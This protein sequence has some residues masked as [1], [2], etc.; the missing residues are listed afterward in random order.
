MDE[1]TIKTKLDSLAEYESQRSL[2]DIQKSELLS[3]VQ[4][5]S[6]VQDIVADGNKRASALRVE[7]QQ[8]AIQIDEEYRA[9]LDAVVVPEEIRA[10]F[11]AIEKQR[12]A[13]VAER[14]ALKAGVYAQVGEQEKSIRE[15]VDA[16]VRETFD[17]VAAR[18]REI[19]EE[20]GGKAQAVDENIAKLKAEIEKDVAAHG[21]SVKGQ[22]KHAVYSPGRVTWNTEKLDGMVALIPQIGEARKV[23]QPSVSIRSI[24]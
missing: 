14:D 17:A 22:Y 23:G 1:I 9:R 6:E 21:A 4:V 2:L 11:D 10:A 12:A 18:K 8:S 13:I 16:K 20:F 5:P 15:A 3:V 19:E 7:A 24:K